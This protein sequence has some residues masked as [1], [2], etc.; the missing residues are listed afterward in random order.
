[1]KLSGVLREYR[2]SFLVTV[3]KRAGHASLD[4]N[5][6]ALPGPGN[7][8]LDIVARLFEL[9]LAQAPVGSF[10]VCT[11]PQ[12]ASAGRKGTVERAPPPWK[13]VQS[14]VGPA[15]ATAVNPDLARSSSES[16]RTHQ[17]P[18]P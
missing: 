14:P 6:A 11:R 4:F 1:M 12:S 16:D 17:E 8:A 9:P 13:P 15:G 7:A 18:P 10:R 2:I 5:E 3:R